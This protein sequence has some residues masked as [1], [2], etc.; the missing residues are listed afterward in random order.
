M[1]SHLPWLA[2][3]S[4]P[5]LTNQAYLRLLERFGSPAAVLKAP[6]AD[7]VQAG[8]I[9]GK[10]A[11]IIAGYKCPGW[12]YAELEAIEKKNY[13]LLTLH[14]PDYPDLLR[15]IADPPPVLYIRGK[16][17]PRQPSVAVV[18]SRRAT[19]YGLNATRKIAGELAEHGWTI[20]SGMARGIDTAAHKAALAAG[21]RTIAVLGTGLNVIYP[22]QNAKLYNEIAESGALVSEFFLDTEPRGHHFPVRNRI[23][24][25]LCYATVVVEAARRSGALITAR[26]ALE[27]GREVFA[28]PGSI[29]S[30]TSRGPHFLIRQGAHLVENAH[31]VTDELADQL[32]PGL[33][34]AAPGIKPGAGNKPAGIELS[35]AERKILELIGPEP[36]HIDEIATGTDTGPGQ[37]A[38]IL[39]QLE[40]KG[41]V[42]QRPGK[43]FQRC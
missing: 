13:T 23:I 7:L 26:L 29:D 2:L 21:K 39:L 41:A 36:V 43:F 3:K 37:L 38:S 34:E 19:A 20:V 25:G 35:A 12:V 31:Q 17:Y 22:R 33:I 10:L 9:S 15:H 11:K 40:L 42:V 18:G 27:Q 4:V 16:L 8:G 6:A 32:D 28:V 30:A 5:G 24:S 1:E 14:D